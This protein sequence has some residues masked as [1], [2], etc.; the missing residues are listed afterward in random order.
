MNAEIK[1]QKKILRQGLMAH[2]KSLTKN[3]REEAS[4]QML[5]HIVKS[6]EY[7]L[8]GT[9][10]I[11]VGQED[12]VNTLLII[13]DALAKGKRVAVPKIIGPGLME[14]CELEA[15]ED[16]YPN[17]FGILEPKEC[18]YRVDPMSID[19]AYIPCLAYTKDG[20]R[21][22]H[23]GGY[24]DRFLPRGKFNRTLL[25]FS[26]MEVETLPLEDFD[27]KVQMIL[28]EHGLERV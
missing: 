9:I 14:A 7:L 10:F 24:Y 21:L 18:L 19:V 12:E 16:L 26:E 27:E 22:G 11:Y 3:Y 5:S 28:T 25:A 23:G 1:E 4:E 8:A 6:R 17:R 2:R 15:T 20:H 13:E